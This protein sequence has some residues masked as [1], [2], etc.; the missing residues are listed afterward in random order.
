MSTVIVSGLTTQDI[1]AAAALAG[2][3]GTVFFPNGT[4]VADDVQ[5][6]LT[7]QTWQ[8][9]RYAMLQ[10]SASASQ[11][12]II[13]CKANGWRLRGGTVADSAGNTTP[14]GILTTGYSADIAETQVNNV[15]GS[16]IVGGNADFRLRDTDIN[17][18][19][20]FGAYW[21][22]TSTQRGPQIDRVRV[23]KQAG[24]NPQ[25]GIAVRAAGT[26]IWH[27]GTTIADCYVEMAAGPVANSVGIDVW[28]GW[29]PYLHGNET[30]NGRIAYSFYL[31][32]FGRFVS[33]FACAPADYAYELVAVSY[34]NISHNNGKGWGPGLQYFIELSGGSNY[35]NITDNNAVGFTQNVHGDVLNNIIR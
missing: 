14:H 18:P 12:P 15:N 5:V 19:L 8:L 3:G 31:S 30:L 16:A 29:Q 10:K 27:K 17:N 13:E 9:E 1:L 23:Y 21:N 35:N 33:N 25:S 24:M 11:T 7:D 2:S 26:N 20:Y 28:Q 32:Q 34:S 22:A 4:Y 6:L